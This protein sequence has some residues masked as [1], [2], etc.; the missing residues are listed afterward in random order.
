MQWFPYLH[1][2][3]HPPYRWLLHS[4]GGLVGPCCYINGND[5]NGCSGET[6]WEWW[7]VFC[8][9]LSISWI[10][11]WGH[12]LQKDPNTLLLARAE[13]ESLIQRTFQRELVHRREERNGLVTFCVGLWCWEYSG[14]VV[15][16]T[17]ALS[18]PGKVALS[19]SLVAGTLAATWMGSHDHPESIF[20]AFKRKHGYSQCKRKIF[21]S[22][23]MAFSYL[24]ILSQSSCPAVYDANATQ[25]GAV[26]SV[27]LHPDG[28]H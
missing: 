19:V 2:L 1:L 10:T 9:R 11:T 23:T 21:G 4:C 15:V 3:S 28:N 8:R 18:D 12:S 7:S 16:G 25:H 5:D 20:V 22:R 24:S 13:D 17:Q 27:V 14:V 6:P 26:G